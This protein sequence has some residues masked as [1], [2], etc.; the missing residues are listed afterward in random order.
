MPR[1]VDLERVPVG[2]LV[3]LVIENRRMA[4]MRYKVGNVLPIRHLAGVRRGR[5]EHDERGAGPHLPN[6]V[7]G[8]FAAAVEFGF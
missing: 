3:R 5:V 7:V 4:G 8:D 1:L 6:D 2:S